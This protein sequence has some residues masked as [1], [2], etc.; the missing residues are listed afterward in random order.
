MNAD[1]MKIAAQDKTCPRCG[2]KFKCLGDGDCWCESYPILQKDFLRI[3]QEYSDCLCPECLKEYT[4][5]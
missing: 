3:T 4:S 5:D 2:A 1:N